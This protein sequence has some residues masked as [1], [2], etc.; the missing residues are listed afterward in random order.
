MP[1]KRQGVSPRCECRVKRKPFNWYKLYSPQYFESKISWSIQLELNSQT[2]VGPFQHQWKWY[3][4][5]LQT[6]Q[7]NSSEHVKNML[8]FVSKHCAKFLYQNR[9]KICAEYPYYPWSCCTN[10]PPRFWFGDNDRILL[11]FTKPKEDPFKSLLLRNQ[12]DCEY[13]SHT[14]RNFACFD[15]QSMQHAEC[16][17]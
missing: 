17:S 6:N 14:W 11:L 9:T 7:K 4:F 5:Q 1:R 10:R 15:C 3:L 2:N 8:A 16:W 13:H 12:L